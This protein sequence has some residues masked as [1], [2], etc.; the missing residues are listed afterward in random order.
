MSKFKNL[1]YLQGTYKKAIQNIEDLRKP[2]DNM[3]ISDIPGVGKKISA[4]IVEIME[5]GELRE[6]NR[7]I[8]VHGDLRELMDVKGIGIR[9]AKKIYKKYRATTKTDLLRLLQSG[10]IKSPTLLARLQ[11]SSDR[12][13]W[14]EAFLIYNQVADQIPAETIPTGSLRRKSK[15]VGDIDLLVEDPSVADIFCNIGPVIERGQRKCAIVINNACVELNIIDKDQWGTALLH[16]TGSRGF[17][18]KL[19]AE[20]KQDGWCLNEYGLFRNGECH[21]FREEEE[22]FDFLGKEYVAPTARSII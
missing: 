2:L 5:T 19:R 21:S 22:V 9:K 6:L 16:M 18:R 3:V 15:M 13:S 7:Q 17:N 8:K 12:I 4:K 11:V 1:K 14:D 10:K 20:I